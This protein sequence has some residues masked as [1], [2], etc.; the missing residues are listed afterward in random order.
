LG[1]A[2]VL[3]AD[4]TLEAAGVR[5]EGE[6]VWGA[7]PEWGSRQLAGVSGLFVGD[8]GFTQVSDAI[9]LKAV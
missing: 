5:A 2:T 7:G 1:V 9:V 6:H 8:A 4:A 3:V